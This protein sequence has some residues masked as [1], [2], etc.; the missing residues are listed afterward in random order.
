M[1][2]FIEDSRAIIFCEVSI[3]NCIPLPR[4]HIILFLHKRLDYPEQDVPNMTQSLACQKD[5]GDAGTW[6]LNLVAKFLLSELSKHS[7]A[8]LF[9]L[10]CK[11]HYSA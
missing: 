2:N 6:W 7:G 1:C 5:L 11:Q 10:S 8:R 3:K 9:Q 4:I